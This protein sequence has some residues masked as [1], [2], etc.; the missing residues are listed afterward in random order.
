MFVEEK[1]VVEAVKIILQTLKRFSFWPKK[2]N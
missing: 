2:N 1:I